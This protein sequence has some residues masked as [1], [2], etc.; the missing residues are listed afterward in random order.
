[1]SG[2]FRAVPSFR[3]NASQYSATTRDSLPPGT[4]LRTLGPSGFSGLCPRFG[5]SVGS[6]GIP[7][8]RRAGTP[9]TCTINPNTFILNTSVLKIIVSG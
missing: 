5:A 2:G 8:L 9:A 7:S 3:P 4:P 6:I 1:M